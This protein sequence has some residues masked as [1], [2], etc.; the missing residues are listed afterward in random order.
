MI[1]IENV[2]LVCKGK[3]LENRNR[4]SRGPFHMIYIRY[5]YII[6]Q[7]IYKILLLMS[8]ALIRTYVIV[9]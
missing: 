8:I 7:N 6:L 1:Q 2:C 4:E 3:Y 9:R 5:I